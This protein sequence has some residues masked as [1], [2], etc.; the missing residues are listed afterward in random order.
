MTPCDRPRPRSWARFCSAALL[1]LARPH[2]VIAYA[3]DHTAFVIGAASIGAMGLMLATGVM[4]AL[5]R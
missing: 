1:A 4:L 2:Q 5:R 3:Q